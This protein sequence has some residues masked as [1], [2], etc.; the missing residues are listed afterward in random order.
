MIRARSM[1]V[2]SVMS[3]SCV[4]IDDG[5]E[6]VE[7]KGFEQAISNTLLEG[8]FGGA[9]VGSDGDSGDVDL[10]L[11]QLA[12]Q[13]CTGLA[14]LVGLAVGGSRQVHIEQNECGQFARHGVERG[15]SI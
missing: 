9:G 1:G 5:E 8:C 6:V 15:L 3:R 10:A 2:G 4:T 13:G 11:T 7:V 14:G 12:E